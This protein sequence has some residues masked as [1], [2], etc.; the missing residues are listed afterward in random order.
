MTI[1]PYRETDF[2]A[3]LDSYAACKLDELMYEEQSFRLRPL[4]NDPERLEGFLV[5]QVL[6]LM[7]TA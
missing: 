1:R 4:D 3:I 7:R 6:C 2:S 5:S